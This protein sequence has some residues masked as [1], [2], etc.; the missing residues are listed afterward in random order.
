MICYILQWFRKSV[1]TQWNPSTKLR[2]FRPNNSAGG[3]S[4]FG[5]KLRETLQSF[6]AP[7]MEL[8]QPRTWTTQWVLLPNWQ[9]P[10]SQHP[11]TPQIPSG[12]LIVTIC[13]IFPSPQLF[14]NI[15]RTGAHDLGCKHT[16]RPEVVQ[17]QPR[18]WDAYELACVWGATSNRQPER[19][20]TFSS[21]IAT[22][23]SV[24]V[25]FLSLAHQEY[26]PD[27]A[28]A[29]PKKKK[30]DGA[31]PTPSTDHVAPPGDRS[32]LVQGLYCLPS[33]PSQLN[34]LYLIS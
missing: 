29:P 25:C 3:G 33:H 28:S 8:C 18:T 17:Q 11:A 15:Q 14:H 1:T 7:V 24:S 27:Q 9:T 31:P 13:S 12:A 6:H 23:S 4:S 30:P 16:R 26:N 2:L 10:P 5:R 34:T 19:D 22:L 20:E 32:R 21:F